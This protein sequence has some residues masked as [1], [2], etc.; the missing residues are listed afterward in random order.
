MVIQFEKGNP[1]LI[2]FSELNDKGKNIN[3]YVAIPPG[4]NRTDLLWLNGNNL[5]LKT[6]HH[7]DYNSVAFV[8]ISTADERM[9][10]YKGELK[11]KMKY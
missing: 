6:S 8:I 10:Y 5:K 4:K 9:I 7:Y 11:C 3:H 1:N 2:R